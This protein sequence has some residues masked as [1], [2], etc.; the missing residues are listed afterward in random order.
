M[1][2]NPDV[3]TR[4]MGVME[5]CTFCVQRIRSVKSEYKDYGQNI[6]PDEA[7]TK[8][9]PCSS[10]CGSDCIT[11]GNLKDP[12]SAVSKKFANER[13]FPMLAELNTKPGVRYLARISHSEKETGHGGGH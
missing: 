12:E 13:A 4:T 3:S 5:K 2:L 7:L 9:L 1:M 6:V 8:L 11:F 10:A